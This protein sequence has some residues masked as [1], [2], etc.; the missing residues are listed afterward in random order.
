MLNIEGGATRRVFEIFEELAAIP[1]GSGNVDRI[2]DYLVN[3]ANRQGLVCYQDALKNVIIIKEASEGYERE[4]ALILQGHMDMVAVQTKECTVDMTKEGL[5]LATK[6]DYLYAEGTSLGA[7]DGIAVAMALAILES[8]TIK[9]PRLEVVITVDEEVGMEGATF[10]DLSLLKGHRMLNFD[11][12]EEGTFLVSCAG[13]LRAKCEYTVELSECQGTKFCMEIDGLLGG[14]SGEEIHRERGNANKLLG[15]ILYELSLQVPIRLVFA[16]GGVA[17]NA[18]PKTANAQIVVSKENQS[19][20]LALF[21]NIS[22]TI[23]TE[24][25]DRDQDVTFTLEPSEEETTHAISAADTY[26]VAAFLHALPNGVQGM[27]ASI[28]GLVETSLNLGILRCSEGHMIAEL[29]LRSSVESKKAALRQRVEAVVFLLGG[30]IHISGDYP[31][32]QYREHSVLRQKMVDTYQKMYGEQPK[33]EAIHAGLECGI[34]A[35][36]ISDF[37]CVSFGPNM[38]DIHT[39][40][41]RLSITSTKRVW[42]FLTTLLAAKDV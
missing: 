15:R 5:K 29:S 17:D 34:I 30:E 39:T 18:I 12:G 31:G 3:F 13:G 8:K 33:I 20:M 1:H 42:E 16:E 2:S 36:K 35:G 9:H 22:E 25:A 28:E 23:K 10:I 21:H 41:E 11:S 38:F 27:S 19:Q 26:K 4:P 24:L 32:W 37:D 40:E 14:H 6:G 7:D